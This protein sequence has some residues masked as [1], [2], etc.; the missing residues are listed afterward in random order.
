MTILYI[1]SKHTTYYKVFKARHRKRF[2]ELKQD[3]SI[4]ETLNPLIA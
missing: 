1:A 3:L 2:R 4:T